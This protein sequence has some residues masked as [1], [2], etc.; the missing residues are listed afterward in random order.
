LRDA[1]RAMNEE[2]QLRRELASLMKQDSPP[3]TG[4]QLL[5]M[6]SLISCLTYDVESVRVRR[7]AEEELDL[8][9]LR[10]E[11][12]YSPSDSARIAVR[13]QALFETAQTRIEALLEVARD[14]R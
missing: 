8:P 9:Y 1:I 6:K 10:I 3:L 4:R 5:D 7:V 11:T 14:R 13:V 12:D 2:R